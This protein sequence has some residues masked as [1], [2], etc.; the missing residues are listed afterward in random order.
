MLSMLNMGGRRYITSHIHVTPNY[1]LV[2]RGKSCTRYT[3]SRY[4]KLQ[5]SRTQEP[6]YTITLHHTLLLAIA[7]H[8]THSRYTHLNTSRP[9]EPLYTTTLLVANVYHYTHSLYTN[10]TLFD[11]CNRCT[12]SRYTIHV[13][14]RGNRCARSRSYNE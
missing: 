10:Y 12:R 11:R 6:L 8:Y 4:T 1:K 14:D 13:A 5:T 2:C 9:W 3:H 7:Y